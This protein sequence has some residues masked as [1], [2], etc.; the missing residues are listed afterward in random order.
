MSKAS[1]TRNYLHHEKV[2][3][4]LMDELEQRSETISKRKQEYLINT[5]M[6]P[7]CQ[8]Q[9]MV[10]TQYFKKNSPFL[11]F[12][13]K[14]KKYPY[15]YNHPKIVGKIIRLHRRTN[16]RLIFADAAIKRFARLVRGTQV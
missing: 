13:S 6:I 9:Y 16:G 2:A 3:L 5:L 11:S 8:V 15:F 12:N 4:R 1:F 10:V 7:I 14:L